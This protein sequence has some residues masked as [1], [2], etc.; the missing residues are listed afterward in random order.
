MNAIFRSMKRLLAQPDFVVAAVLL[1]VSALTLNFAT[2]A[3]KLH[4]QKQPVPLR[5]AALDDPKDGIPETLGKWMLVSRDKPLDPDMEH[6]LGTQ[7]YLNRDYV[8]TSILGDQISALK[9]MTPDELAV[10]LASIE[11]THPEAVLH[12]GMFYYTGLVDTVAHIPD[13]CMIADGYDVASYETIEPAKLGTYSDGRDR[14]LS[15]RYIA[16]DDQTGRG[17]TSRNVAYLFHV[18]GHYESDPLGVRRSLQN[19]LERYGYYAKVEL[20]TVTPARGAESDPFHHELHEK[21]LSAMEDFLSA[22]LP[23]VER[24]LPD[25]EKVHGRGPK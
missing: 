22:A 24:C 9:G 19:L 5:V 7:K 12:V 15:F 6:I 18:N 10:A 8:D 13:R 16:F 11:Q 17:R 21:S 23:E 4:F 2:S 20:M 14:K 1:G 3:L 25:W